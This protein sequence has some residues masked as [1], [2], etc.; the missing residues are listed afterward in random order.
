M[1]PG[2][3]VGDGAAIN[4]TG[5]I[6]SAISTIARMIGRCLFMACISA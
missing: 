1:L 3:P 2:L 6:T 4:R 5:I